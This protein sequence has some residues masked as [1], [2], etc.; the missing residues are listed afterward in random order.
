[1]EADRCVLS[2]LEHNSSSTVRIQVAIH[3][4]L[5]FSVRVDGV[6]TTYIES[7]IKDI[8]ASSH[9]TKQEL[10]YVLCAEWEGRTKIFSLR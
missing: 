1:M 3:L 5:C 10:N 6:N 4:K 2:P 8:I 9:Y 7:S